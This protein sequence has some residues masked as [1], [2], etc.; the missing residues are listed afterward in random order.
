MVSLKLLP[1]SLP[2]MASAI[3]D[4]SPPAS[5]SLP[6][7]SVVV[8]HTMH[9]YRH[10]E[11]VERALHGPGLGSVCF[12]NPTRVMLQACGGACGGQQV[13]GRTGHNAP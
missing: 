11:A 8:L 5:P 2:G 10:S 4:E 12:L 3:E 13:A 6:F 1:S 7:F 9:H